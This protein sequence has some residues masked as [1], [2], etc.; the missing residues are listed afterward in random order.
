VKIDVEYEN[1]P[2]GI[3]T[4]QQKTETKQRISDWCY[5]TEFF[6]DKPLLLK[7]F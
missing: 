1:V 5:F 3:S 4:E 7:A 2:S 6:Y